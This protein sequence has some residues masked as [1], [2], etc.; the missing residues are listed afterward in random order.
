MKTMKYVA[1]GL[2]CASCL[3]LQA[4]TARLNHQQCIDMAL[5]NSL[6]VQGGKMAVS[7]A[8]TLQKTAFE[9]D[10]TSISFGQDFTSGGNP[11]NGITLSQSFDCPSVYKV[12]RK[13]LES[14]TAVASSQL[15]I[16]RNELVKGVLENYYAWVYA[17]YTMTIL[18]RQ[19]GVYRQFEKL[20]SIRYKAGETN[21]LEVMN[22]KRLLSE[23]QMEMQKAEKNSMDYLFNLQQLMNTDADFL[24]ADSVL[25]PLPMKIDPLSDFSETPLGRNY[26]AR[27]VNGER[28]VELAKQDFKPTFSVGFTLQA[29]ISGLNPYNVDRDRF[30][31]GDFLAFE[32]GVS[33]PIFRGSQRAK[34]R[35]ASQEVEILQNER[36]IAEQQMKSQHRA[37]Y[38]QYSRAKEAL[39]FY[40]GQGVEQARAMADLSKV[41]YE[42][43]E[44][45]YVEYMQNQ[46]TALDV[47]MRYAQAVNEYNQALINLSYING[48]Y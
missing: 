24:P 32:V 22:A 7:R 4:Q 16:I 48:K 43:G 47:Q 2:F 8:E 29:C 26:Q 12:R 44:I 23:N 6:L 34:V 35:A 10:K 42:Q 41:E 19:D 45:G 27:I 20:A 39:G 40:G 33:V 15:P 31:K 46:I 28:N 25:V 11:D 3:A 17:R 36:L 30:S 38:N 9:L 37:A 21:S 1:M 18:Q 14:E 5:D 13:Y